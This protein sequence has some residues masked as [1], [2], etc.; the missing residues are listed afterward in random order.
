MQ[1]LVSDFP[2][3]SQFTHFAVCRWTREI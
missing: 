3:T 1:L 2:W